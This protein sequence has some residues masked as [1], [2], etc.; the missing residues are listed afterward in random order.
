MADLGAT[1]EEPRLAQMRMV[2]KDAGADD[3]AT[4]AFER[5][6]SRPYVFI[7]R[8]DARESGVWKM[9]LMDPFGNKAELEGRLE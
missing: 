6:S 5:F 1:P 3:N 2:R 8:R 7:S 9:E 4:H